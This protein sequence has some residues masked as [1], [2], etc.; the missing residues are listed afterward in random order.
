MA[1]LCFH[2]PLAALSGT[3][4]SWGRASSRIATVSLLG[5]A[6]PADSPGVGVPSG[7]AVRARHSGLYWQ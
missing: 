2:R 7:G 6:L 4:L 1:L 3:P 5:L